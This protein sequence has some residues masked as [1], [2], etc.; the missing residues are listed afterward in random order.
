[1]YIPRAFAHQTEFFEAIAQVAREF[2]PQV[3]S[4]TPVLGTDWE[5]E[6]AVF[7]EVVFADDAVPRSELL[8]F[9]RKVSRAIVWR[10]RP[11]EEWGVLPHFRYLTQ[12]ERSRLKEPEWA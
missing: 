5:G 12:T 7:I 8:S 4:V 6:S 3:V 2:Q 11:L 1:M 9:T 10:V